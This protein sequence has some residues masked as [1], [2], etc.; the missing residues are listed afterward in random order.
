MSDTETASLGGVTP[1]FGAAFVHVMRGMAT[2]VDLNVLSA[3]LDRLRDRI[4]TVESRV[5]DVLE[6]DPEA[7]KYILDDED[8]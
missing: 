5:R 1:G 6:T 8:A 4:E 3:E 7:V 2:D